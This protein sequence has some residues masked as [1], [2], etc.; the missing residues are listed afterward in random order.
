MRWQRGPGCAWD[1]PCCEMTRQTGPKHP[2]GDQQ[3]L[4]PS[5]A[6]NVSSVTAKTF[7]T[8]LCDRHHTASRRTL[9]SSHTSVTNHSLTQSTQ[10]VTAMLAWLVLTASAPAIVC[11]LCA[12]VLAFQQ[13]PGWQW[14]LV[15]S[16]GGEFAALLLIS[17]LR[18]FV[19]STA[20]IAPS[21]VR[22]PVDSNLL[23]LRLQIGTS[24]AAPRA[25]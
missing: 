19:R 14:F 24:S 22:Q 15:L 6:Q 8:P 9:L 7:E 13:R 2:V 4:R 1:D 3:A 21:S 23:R 5:T 17:H 25:S 11:I 10:G 18:T 16:I 12:A 20:A